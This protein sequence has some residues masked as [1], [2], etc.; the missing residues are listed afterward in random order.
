MSADSRNK[1][2]QEA[3]SF[4]D[5]A[6]CVIEHEGRLMRMLNL[7]TMSLINGLM[8]NGWLNRQMDTGR[9]ARS[10]ILSR[11]EQKPV[12]KGRDEEAWG[13]LEHERLPVLSYPYEWSFSMLADA[14]ILHL[15]L[16]EELLDHGLSLKDATAFNVM[17]DRAKPCFIDFGSIERPV[18]LDAWYA[19]GQFCRMFL[20][21][22]LLKLKR[23]LPLPGLFLP[24]LDGVDIGTCYRALG[25]RRSWSPGLFL[26]VGL[27]HA[28][29]GTQTAK[30]KSAKKSEPSKKGDPEVQKLNLRR[31][32]RK[33]ER[34][35]KS[36][37]LGG[38][39]SDYRVTHSYTSEDEKKKAAFVERVLRAE[40]PEWVHDVGC[41]TGQYSRLAAAQGCRVISSDADHDSIE[42][43]YRE[44][45]N[46]PADIYPLVG[47][48]AAPSP[49]VGYMSQERKPLLDRIQTDGVLALALIHHLMVHARL[50]LTMMAELFAHLTRRVLIIEYVH[51]SDEMFET[52]LAFR[53]D[54]FSWL[55]LDS[56]RQA[57]AERFEELAVEEVKPGKRWMIAYRRKA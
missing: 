16:Q 42:C 3:A 14:G 46:H 9:I 35:K 47:N 55:T 10:R 31:L 8:E 20:F 36:Y 2:V 21:P 37:R 53:T 30:P 38:V 18:K 52:L 6:G 12:L 11:E 34:L 39:W 57:F 24:H 7:E 33:L 51:T 40:K 41:N 32:R 15:D 13:L 27:Q 26:D 43:L 25:K 22:L 4:R 50:T 54:D 5:P 1:P 48:I 45:Q 49:G 44:L 28:L 29:H 19:Y 23:S 17:F 56:F